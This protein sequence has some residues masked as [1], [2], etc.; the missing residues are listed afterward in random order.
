MDMQNLLNRPIRSNK[1]NVETLRRGF[2]RRLTICGAR[3]IW[4]QRLIVW[5]TSAPRQTWL[6]IARQSNHQSGARDREKDRNV[7]EINRVQGVC[8]SS[9]LML[10][11]ASVFIHKASIN[12]EILWRK[13]RTTMKSRNSSA[14]NTKKSC[15]D[16]R[17]NC[18]TF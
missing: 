11:S 15:A 17:R 2:I 4:Q 1:R 13:S 8:R 6:T 14:S 5:T 18:V 9:L 12:R 7:D 16:C 3:R 10:P